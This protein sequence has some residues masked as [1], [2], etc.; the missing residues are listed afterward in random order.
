MLTFLKDD[1]IYWSINGLLSELH[2]LKLL[3]N[4]TIYQIWHVWTRAAAELMVP[5]DNQPNLAELHLDQIL[6][7]PLRVM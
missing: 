6:R 5:T 4:G 2:G 1:L 3:P 7:K